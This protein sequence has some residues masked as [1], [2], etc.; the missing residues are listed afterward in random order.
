MSSYHFLDCALLVIFIEHSYLILKQHT[1]G[2]EG[3]DQ[4]A[5]SAVGFFVLVL[6][7]SKLTS[8]LDCFVK[9]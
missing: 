3:C 1:V 8:L 2:N 5:V 6:H 7:I 9:K 4:S